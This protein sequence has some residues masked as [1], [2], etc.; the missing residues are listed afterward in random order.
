MHTLKGSGRMVGARDLSEF[1]WACENL[2]NRL[3][4][5]T[6]TR[7]PAIAT[8]LHDAVA[9]LPQLVDALE[10]GTPVKFDA[11][12]LMARA[13]ALAAAREGAESTPTSQPTVLATQVLQGGRPYLDAAAATQVS[14]PFVEDDA[15]GPE[16]SA[17]PELAALEN[18]PKSAA[19]DAAEDPFLALQDRAA[20]APDERAG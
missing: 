10:H 11:K 13:H 4:D 17:V 8:T 19:S 6:L 9:G 3:L 15:T 20:A 7:S 14:A 18:A 16:F 2:L 12:A 5:N 1:A